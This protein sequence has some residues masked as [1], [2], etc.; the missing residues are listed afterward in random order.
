MKT[1]KELLEQRAKLLAEVDGADEKRFDEIQ[2]EI[3]KVDALI[4]E[5]KKAEA[6]NEA[7]ERA[8]R[9][10]SGTSNVAKP[11]EAMF[12]QG[13]EN[14]EQSADSEVE[15]RAK[16]LKESKQ[17]TIP[18]KELRA[19]LSSGTTQPT[20]AS[21]GGSLFNQVS[22]IVDLVKVEDTE[23]WGE[24]KVSYDDSYGTADAGE[25]GTAPTSSNPVF[26]QVTIKPFLLEIVAE[27][28][29][30]ISNLTPINYMKRVNDSIKISLRKKLAT[31]ITSGNGTSAAMGIINSVNDDETP[32]AMYKTYEVAAVSGAG[33][34]TSDTLKNI[35]LQ[36]GSDEEI[37]ANA[38]LFLNKTDLAAFGAVR[39]T[40]EKKAVYEIIPDMSNPNV[41]LIKEGGI[42]VKYCINSNVTGLSG[43]AQGATAKKT[44]LYGDPTNY[45]LDLFKDI[46]I[47]VSEH[48]KFSAGLLVIRGEALVGGAVTKK[49]GFVVVTLAANAG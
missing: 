10:A 42:T 18:V 32:A 31:W 27:I 49:N 33:A 46:D 30:K 20:K 17:T 44:M 1:L 3:R 24:N 12:I 8:A 15:K 7:E 9:P 5:A 16:Q 2:F 47:R 23:G 43:L 34:I 19:L 45:E 25:E 22:S 36:Y 37:G 26:K 14:R 41:G 35:V 29:N 39:G 48:E 13:A 38:I 28:S 4:T 11:M 40:N 21:E 6:D